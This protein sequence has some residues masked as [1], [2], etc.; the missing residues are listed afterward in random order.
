MK[1]R[2]KN[3]KNYGF[4]EGE[5]KGEKES[6]KLKEYCKNPDF[7]EHI[8]L[9]H[10]AISANS[11]LAADLYYSI[12]NSLSYEDISRVKYIPISKTD[13]YAYQRKCMYIFRDLLRM[14]GKWE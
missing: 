13:F 14:H 5:K 6:S 12:V 7:D 2:Q 11:S 8:N 3:Y 4:A 1:T 9:M 10:A